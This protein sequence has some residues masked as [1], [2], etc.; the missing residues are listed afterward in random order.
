MLAEPLD[1][2]L[3][4]EFGENAV[5]SSAGSTRQIRVIFDDDFESI[6]MG[7]DGRLITVLCKG[8][9]ASNVRQGDTLAVRGQQYNV[10]SVQPDGVMTTLELRHG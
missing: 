6:P 7:A 2:F 1:V 3:G 10:T 4:T 8:D 5:L 9:D